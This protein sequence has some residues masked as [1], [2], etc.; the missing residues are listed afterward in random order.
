MKSFIFSVLFLLGVLTVDA[1]H[2]SLLRGSTSTSTDSTMAFG[3]GLQEGILVSANPV[4]TTTS[5]ASTTSSILPVSTN[6]FQFPSGTVQTTTKTATTTDPSAF[7]GFG[8]TD[9][10]QN[11]PESGCISS[12]VIDP[13]DQKEPLVDSSSCLQGG[14]ATPCPA[15]Y[16]P[17]LCNS[18]CSYPAICEARGAGY[19]DDDCVREDCP[20]SVTSAFCSYLGKAPVACAGGCEYDN[21]CIAAGTDLSG[22]IS[23]SSAAIDPKDQKVLLA[24]SSCPQGGGATPCP[25]IYAPVLCNSTCSYPAICEARGAG[26]FDD[27]CVS[28]DPDRNDTSL[29]PACPEVTLD[30]TCTLG[31][32]PVRCGPNDCT[33]DNPCG[34]KAA[35]FSPEESCKPVNP[36]PDEI[37]PSSGCRTAGIGPITITKNVAPVICN[38]VCKYENFSVARAAGYSIRDCRPLMTMAGAVNEPPELSCPIGN[39]GIAP[40]PEISDPVLCIGTCQYDN[41]CSAQNGPGFTEED[42]EPIEIDLIELRDP[43]PGT[44]PVPCDKMY[45][46]VI[47]KD[48]CTYGNLC[49]GVGAGFLESDCLP[50]CPETGPV[51]CNKMYAPVICKDSCTYGNLCLGVGAGFLE[52]DCLL[53]PDVR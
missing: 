43:C 51:P 30:K 4:P 44:G 46:P 38:D 50:E 34:A 49:L 5:T 15:I 11:C 40:C 39:R 20:V 52:S 21:I 13:E 27:D 32:D 48:I 23:I 24:S 35:G 28:K 14:G 6:P 10:L 12:A 53:V 36:D 42:C 7:R 41:F 3:R 17:V 8:S 18:T 16:A 9:S 22:C 45:D 2:R 1:D 47:C 29:P 37:D 31:L 26:Y 25:A 19:T 33:Y